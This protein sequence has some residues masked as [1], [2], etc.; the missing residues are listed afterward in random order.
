L[1]TSGPLSCPARGRGRAQVRRR[2]C[3][4]PRPLAAVRQVY[5]TLEASKRLKDSQDAGMDLQAYIEFRRNFK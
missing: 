5:C 4:R 2:R 3:A 1:W